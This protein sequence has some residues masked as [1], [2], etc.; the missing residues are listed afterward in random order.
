[1]YK[2]ATRENFTYPTTRGLCVTSDLWSMPLTGSFSLND[3]AIRLDDTLEKSAKKSFVE[4]SS[5]EDTTTTMKLNIVKD[6]IA[7][8]LAEKAARKDAAS[9]KAKKDK[10]LGVLARK[11]D[12]ALEDKTEAE[13]LAELEKL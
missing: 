6:I 12:A 11:Q 4:A 8:K 2:T 3:T 13:I 7:D 10:L 5:S 1:M 9:V